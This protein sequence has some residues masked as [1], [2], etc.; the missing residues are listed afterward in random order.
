MNFCQ[1]CGTKQKPQ[2]TICHN[3]KK[4]LNNETNIEK[5]NHKTKSKKSSS[6]GGIVLSIVNG[7]ITIIFSIY[8]IFSY[9]I[10]K[11]MIV[12]GEIPDSSVWLSS[13][14]F[15]LLLY[16]CAIFIYIKKGG[17]AFFITMIVS[18]I[19]IFP[20]VSL[21]KAFKVFEQSLGN[22]YGDISSFKNVIILGLV[23]IVTVNILNI[24]TLILRKI[25]K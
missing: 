7:L 1:Y 12:R 20:Y 25:I 15:I 10:S 23:G 5:T 6:F 2:A 8:L 24:V 13:L 3:C 11:E 4:S 21:L 16:L 18:I 17:F 14:L 22:A 19:M 9:F